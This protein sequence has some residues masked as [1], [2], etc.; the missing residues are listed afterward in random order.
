MYFFLLGT[1]FSSLAL[2]LI[3]DH[4]GFSQI[5]RSLDADTSVKPTKQNNSNENA[6]QSI[7]HKFPKDRKE[8][9]SNV[10]G[11]CGN[12]YGS[13][14]DGYCCSEAVSLDEYECEFQNITF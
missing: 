9:E 1:V 2:S 6:G 7:K 3:E 5:P 8:D 14:A 4:N 11:P 13:C 12:G 10:D